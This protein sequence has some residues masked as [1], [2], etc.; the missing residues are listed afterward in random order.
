MSDR[1]YAKRLGAQ[2]RD[3]R[4]LLRLNQTEVADL[5]GTTQRTVSQVEAGKAASVELYLA[6]ADVFGLQMTLQSRDPHSPSRSEAG[7]VAS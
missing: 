2:L 7:E 6:I 4:K 5:A 3:R 1:T